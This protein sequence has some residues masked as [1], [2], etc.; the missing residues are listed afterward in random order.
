MKRN[1]EKQ[2]VEQVVDLKALQLVES[3]TFLDRA[4]K[5]TDFNLDDGTAIFIAPRIQVRPGRRIF[6]DVRGEANGNA[7]FVKK[8]VRKPNGDAD[9]Y[10]F[11]QLG[12]AA[13]VCP[14]KITKEIRDLFAEVEELD[15]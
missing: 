7:F 1:K 4:L 14:E 3:T 10:G 5:R 8:I 11:V 2:E 15:V 13:E 6:H 9:F 12:E